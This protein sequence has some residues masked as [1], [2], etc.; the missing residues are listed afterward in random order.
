MFR[1]WHEEVDI[2]LTKKTFIE[3]LNGNWY[4]LLMLIVSIFV[5]I[6]TI[7][8]NVFILF[9]VIFY[10][11]MRNYTNIQFASISL[12]DLLGISLSDLKISKHDFK[13][14]CFHLKLDP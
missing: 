4:N 10:K 5:I 6:T 1:Y 2:Q 3:I 13:F 8:L 7:L 11:S 12:A 14:N 9:V